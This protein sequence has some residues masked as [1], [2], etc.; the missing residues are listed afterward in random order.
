MIDEH[1]AAFEYDWRTRFH[2]PLEAIGGRRMSWGEALRLAQVL[3]TDPSSQVGA[4][5]EGWDFAIS[6]EAAAL[7][8][9]FDLEHAK[10]VKKPNPHPG[11]PWK[12]RGSSRRRGDAAGRSREEVRRILNAHG[13]NL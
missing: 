2:L 5:L 4:A 10:A 9:L 3:R 7:L 8:D 1:R 12:T 11:R 13:H 6:R